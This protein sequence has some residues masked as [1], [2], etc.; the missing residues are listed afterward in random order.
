MESDFAA[1]LVKV[2][3]QETDVAAEYEKITQENK[4]MKTSKEQD[5]EYKN[6]ELKRL[7]M[8][9]IEL[10]SDDETGGA[11]GVEAHEER[12]ARGPE[13]QDQGSPQDLR[14]PR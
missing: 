12:P 4:A 13:E 9:L 7:S 3:T 5:V 11:E 8:K 6:Q 2:E 10:T 14:L 1:N